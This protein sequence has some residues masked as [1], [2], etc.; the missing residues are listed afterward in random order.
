[1]GCMGAGD[2]FPQEVQRLSQRPAVPSF[3]YQGRKWGS[4]SDLSLVFKNKSNLHIENF[5]G[6][7]IHLLNLPDLFF[8]LRKDPGSHPMV[9]HQNK[10]RTFGKM[11]VPGL[12][13]TN[14]TVGNCLQ[15]SPCNVIAPSFHQS[16]G[17]LREAGTRKKK[18]DHLIFQKEETKDLS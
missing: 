3:L 8:S 18:G 1:M 6:L 16:R 9:A 2:L 17:R 13:Q 7:R 12:I 11:Q 4:T 14:S 15:V 5:T 10:L